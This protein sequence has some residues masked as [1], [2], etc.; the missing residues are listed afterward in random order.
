L[1]RATRILDRGRRELK[2][3]VASNR[4]VEAEGTMAHPAVDDVRDDRRRVEFQIS[5]QI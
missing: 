2:G 3:T 1:A 4:V 5:L